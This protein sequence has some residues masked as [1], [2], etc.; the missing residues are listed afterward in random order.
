MPIDLLGSLQFLSIAALV[1]FILYRRIRRNIGRQPAR[2][3]RLWVRIGIFAAIGAA[4]LFQAS[5]NLNNWIGAGLGAA[6]GIAIAVYALPHT[7]FETTS[8]GNFYTPNLFIGLGLSTL[9][10]GRVGFR[11]FGASLVLQNAAAQAHEGQQPLTNGLAHAFDNPVTIALFF[12]TAG[13]YVCYCFCV[14]R[15]FQMQASPG[16][17]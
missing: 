16:R 5:S 1:A 12:V 11:F 14:F 7:A 15:H 8:A 4:I 6:L 3:V 2:T 10:V 13:Y 17:Q 9:L